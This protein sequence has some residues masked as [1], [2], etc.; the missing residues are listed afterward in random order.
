MQQF[1]DH[2]AFINSSGNLSLGGGGNDDAAGDS[3]HGYAK[4]DVFIPVSPAVLIST[5]L[6]ALTRIGAG[7]YTRAL[8]ASTT[9]NVIIPF[10]AAYL[11]TFV[12]TAGR[13]ANPHG[14]KVRSLKLA[15]R[16]NTNNITS[17]TLAVY[18]VSLAAAAAVPS[19]T[20]LASTVTGDTLT[21]AANQYLAVAAI[22]APTFM[23]TTDTLIV[24]EAVIVTPGSCTCDLLGAVWHV[25]A[26]LY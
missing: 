10:D 17:I 18:T 26:A 20:E 8:A 1:N 3:T 22:D 9:H 24:G 5:T 16:V 2:N 6:P 25:S 23:V 19:A 4:G 11:R 15:Y 21:A 7:S 14:I 12:A 13:T